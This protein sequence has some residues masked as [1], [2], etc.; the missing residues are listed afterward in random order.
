MFVLFDSTYLELEVS[1][2][3]WEVLLDKQEH[4]KR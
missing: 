1:E 4:L 3:A 2:E